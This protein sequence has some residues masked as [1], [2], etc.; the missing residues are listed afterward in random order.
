MLKVGGLGDT[1][2]LRTVPFPFTVSLSATITPV[3]EQ[4]P[5]TVTVP[6]GAITVPLKL[7]FPLSVTLHLIL[8]MLRS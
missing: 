2:G 1:D 8:L 3:R 4:F 5:L 7:A 6:D